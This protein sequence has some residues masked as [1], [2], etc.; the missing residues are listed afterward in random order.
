MTDLPDDAI[1]V[2]LAAVV[3]C[4][5]CGGSK[6]SPAVGSVGGICPC[7]LGD[8]TV[9]IVTDVEVERRGDPVGGR[10]PWWEVADG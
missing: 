5:N 3:R 10:Q 7:C 4:A 1:K 9:N 8:G 2:V 6:L